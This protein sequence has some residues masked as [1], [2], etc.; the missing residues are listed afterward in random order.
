MPPHDPT[1]TRRALL[2]SAAAAA[3]GLAAGPAAAQL[4]QILG[5]AAGQMGFGQTLNTVND[6]M[7]GMDLGEAEELVMA[8]SYYERFIGQSG[9]RY[10][11]RKAQEA[12]KRF[13]QPILQTSQR[14]GLPWD[15][16]LV[17]ND[18]VNAWALPGGK[19][20]VHK[21]LIRYT[22]TPEELAAV[23]SHELA[24]AEFS[25]GLKQMKNKA[26]TQNLSTYGKQRLVE[27]V[28]TGRG[29]ALAGTLTGEMLGVLEGPIFEMVTSG[30]SQDLEFEADAHIVSVFKLGGYDVSK[31]PDF[32]RT[33]MQ[34][35]P[36]KT[37]ATS[38]LY[39]THPGTKKRVERIEKQ[40]KKEKAGFVV[41]GA[42]VGWAEL[43]Q[44][45]PT[46]KNFRR[47]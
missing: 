9:G 44:S 32:F 45:F 20:A 31:A 15:I 35:V 12:L 37:Q 26:F 16:V 19:L 25:H 22:A 18:T 5:Q 2:A 33:M 39:S 28:S 10:N 41:P 27:Q 42:P 34:L 43:K 8:E 3:A 40:V 30:Y 23:I 4:D 17:D 38:S 1:P 47:A 13:A 24:H 14:R 29:G 11:S 7:K 6:L 36:E 21:G 46:R